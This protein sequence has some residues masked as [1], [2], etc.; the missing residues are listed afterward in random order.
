M[1][2]EEGQWGLG[3]S[4]LGQ[5]AGGAWRTQGWLQQGPR[6]GT[7]GPG[8]PAEPWQRWEAALGE[9]GR[10][11]ME[12]EV[13]NEQHEE[14]LK[15]RNRVS[16]ERREGEKERQGGGRQPALAFLWPLCLAS[17]PAGTTRHARV[18]MDQDVHPLLERTLSVVAGGTP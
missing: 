9:P 10:M 17:G 15:E 2:L 18:S 3:L 6:G 16:H 1:E 12:S 5:G 7:R 13:G 8:G 11:E 14:Q 4:E